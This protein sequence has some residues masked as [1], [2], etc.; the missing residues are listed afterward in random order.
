[1]HAGL[2]RRLITGIAA[3]LVSIAGVGIGNAQ[4]TE[5][6]IGTW[7]LDV[8]KSTFS[9][10]PAPKEATLTIEAAGPGLKVAVA[11]VDGEGKP[12]QWGYTANFDRKEY[13]VTGNNPNAD[14]VSLRRLPNAY[15]VSYKKAGKD[16]I[17]NGVSVSA[18]GK[19]LTVASSGV[20]AQG[21]PVKS[22]LV[23]MRQ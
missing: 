15:R 16:T 6:S 18:D 13:P 14:V 17:V 5:P 21:A 12:T 7:K 8:A 3:A 23:F 11:G 9:P 1:M 20:N 19:T 2:S 10:G 4:S 22:T